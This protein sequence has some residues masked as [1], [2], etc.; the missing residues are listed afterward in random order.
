MTAPIG[1][2]PELKIN[3]QFTWHD[4]AAGKTIEDCCWHGKGRANI[5]C[6]DWQLPSR[7]TYSPLREHVDRLTVLAKTT[8]IP[9]FDQERLREGRPGYK[10]RCQK[11]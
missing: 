9:Q 2:S 4:Q 6:A 3:Q 11:Y 8:C 5:G 7:V 1:S 10:Q